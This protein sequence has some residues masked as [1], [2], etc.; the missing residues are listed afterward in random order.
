MKKVIVDNINES[1]TV[2]VK[3]TEEK[4][5]LAKGYD[6]I[7]EML[8]DAERYDYLIKE[9]ESLLERKRLLKKSIDKK[10]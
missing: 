9:I 10:I 8:N 6:T 7:M 4:I 2:E 5:T 1:I 3:D